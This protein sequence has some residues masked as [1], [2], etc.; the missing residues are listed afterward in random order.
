MVSASK[1]PFDLHIPHQTLL[2]C[3]NKVHQNT[4]P[5]WFLYHLEKE[6]FISV[7]QEP[8]GLLMCFCVVPL[9]DTGVIEVPH[10]DQGLCK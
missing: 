3:K 7:F 8:L 1:A 10:E 9:T 5:H 2:V 4:S 6:F